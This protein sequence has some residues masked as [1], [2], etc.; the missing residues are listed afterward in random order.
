MKD[1]DGNQAFSAPATVRKGSN[2]KCVGCIYTGVPR[3][4]PFLIPAA[5]TQTAM[6]PTPTP[7]LHQGR[8]RFFRRPLRHSYALSSSVKVEPGVAAATPTGAS[9]SSHVAAGAGPSPSS[10]SQGTTPKTAAV[11]PSGSN[12]PSQSPSVKA[13]SAAR[14]GSGT[15]IKMVV[16]LMSIAVFLV[17]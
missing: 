5:P 6:P 15:V 8:K 1:K 12:A 17:A 14:D 11:S 2:T 13:S 9:T 16:G 4:E 7:P 10:S 3:Y